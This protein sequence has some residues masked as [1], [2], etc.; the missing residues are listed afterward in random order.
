MNKWK[1]IMEQ[2]TFRY[3]DHTEKKTFDR[4]PYTAMTSFALDDAL[5]LAISNR[6]SPP[7]LRTWVHDKTIVLGIPDGRLPFIEDGVKLLKSHNYN[8]IIRNSGGLAVALDDGVLNLSL[9]I[10]NIKH[11]TIQDGYE[12]MFDFIKYMLRDL[13]NRIEA[14]EIVGS[15]CPGDYDL[16]IDGIKFAGI[17]QRRIKDSAAVQIYLDVEGNSFERAQIIRQF[18]DLSIRGET[19]TFSYPTVLPNKMGSLSQLLDQPLTVQDIKDR[20][21]NALSDVN[22]RIITT[23]FSEKELTTFEQRFKQMVK[24]NERITNIYKEPSKP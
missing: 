15:Y 8:A 18:Y 13:T 19:T 2:Q 20:A 14:Y 9:I 16:S 6:L 12:A 22:E 7:A 24:R 10:P 4:K 17:S 11:I 3:I 5:A 21:Y 23:P 1:Q